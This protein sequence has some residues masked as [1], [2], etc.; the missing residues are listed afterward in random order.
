MPL[1]VDL[2]A[3]MNASDVEFQVGGVPVTQVTIPAGLASATF[4]IVGVD[5]SSLDLSGVTS[6]QSAGSGRTVFDVSDTAT[7]ALPSLQ[8]LGDV[9]VNVSGTASLANLTS[10]LTIMPIWRRIKARQ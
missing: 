9:D 3:L 4:D 10:L 6:V 1:T 8:T 2:M 7:L 5:D